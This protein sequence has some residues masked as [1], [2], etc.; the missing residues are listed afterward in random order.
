[1]AYF[2]GN[3]KIQTESAPGVFR[4]ISEFVR[5]VSDIQF[6]CIEVTCMTDTSRRT[7]PGLPQ[8]EIVVSSICAPGASPRSEQYNGKVK[9]LHCGQWNE[10]KSACTFCGAPVD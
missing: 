3:V 1:M 2:A 9:C 6:P 7:I 10:Q 5:A 8:G 4:D